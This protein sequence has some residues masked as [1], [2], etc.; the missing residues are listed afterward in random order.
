MKHL[1][2]AI[3]ISLLIGTTLISCKKE[4]VP[5]LTT[6]E[7]TNITGNTA[8][9]GGI[10]TSE[11]SGTVLSRGVC[12]SIGTT[13][14][15]ADSKTQDGAGAGTFSSNLIGLNGATT[16]YIRAYSTNSVGT[17]YGMA[18]SFKTLGQSPTVTTSLASG[19]NA[20]GAKIKGIINCN[21]LSTT[22]TFEYG[23]SISY[24]QT[25]EAIGS[26]MIGNENVSVSATLTNLSSGTIYHYRVKAV[27]SLGTTYGNDITF[28]T[29]YSIGQSFGGGIICYLDNSGQHG[30]IAALNDQSVGIQWY[31]GTNVPIITTG[32]AIGSGQS[33]TIAIISNQGQ[34]TYAAIMC[35]NLVLNNYD[36]W[37][38]PSKDELNTMYINLKAKGLGNFADGHYWSSSEYKTDTNA[39]YQYF[40]LG[41]QNSAGKEYEYY[42]RAIRAF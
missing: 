26:P 11:G 23:T 33:N 7:I 17:G 3:I 9:C 37:F 38:L 39:W 12:W 20:S 22:V 36:D 31:N 24:G 19:V 21:F 34:G 18:M 1:R 40:G 27:N 14:T 16:Y 30:L 8:S 32:M 35:D 5:T 6:T 25:L 28:T 42:V 15:I 41:S 2:I 13:P 10:I 4:E 29:L